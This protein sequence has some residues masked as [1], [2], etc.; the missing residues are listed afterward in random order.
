MSFAMPPVAIMVG[1]SSNSSLRRSIMPSTI[2]A[3]PYTAPLVMQSM[4]L[5]P[6]AFF[7]LDRSMAGSCAVPPERALMERFTPAR[8]EP[9][10]KAPSLSM[11]EKVVAVPISMMICGRG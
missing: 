6:H 11:T 3:L 1:V 2:A 10:R 4:V 7:G 8:M 5:E 9:P